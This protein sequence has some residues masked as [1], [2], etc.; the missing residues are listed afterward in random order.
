[1][2]PLLS[3]ALA[4][5]DGVLRRADHRPLA[6]LIDV[7]L[8]RG[9]L[10]APFRGVYTAPDA[11]H[12]VRLR[13]LTA[14]DPDAVATGA[15]AGDLHGWVP[16]PPAAVSA[17]SRL[18]S[19]QGFALS[20][21]TIPR[22]LTTRARGVRYTSR[23]L[24]AID[25][26]AERGVE[27]IDAALRRGIPLAQLWRAHLATP[28]RPGRG[29][30]RQWL[31]DS[32]TEAWSPLE[33]AA[34]AALHRRGVGGWVANHV[35]VLDGDGGKAYPDIAF[36]SLRLAIEVDGWR[37]HQ[38]KPAFERDRLRD[39]ELACLG[40]QVVRFPGAWVLRHPG[41]FAAQVERIVAAR[42]A[43]LA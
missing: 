20:R 1:M 28:N 10:V 29:R 14:A 15:S 30:V 32:R 19:R 41:R 3:A 16:D 26:A 4:E 25:L 12:A 43:S 8:R 18:R 36:R 23:A 27:E 11:D 42:E 34:H 24:T 7:A 9:D 2:N 21:R 39:A 33:R 31:A 35:V 22:W 37:W 38:G 5:H 17:A 6:H 40:W 13:A